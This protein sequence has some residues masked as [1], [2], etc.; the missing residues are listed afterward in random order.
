MLKIIKY[1][2]TAIFVRNNDLTWEW[3]RITA[4][5]DARRATAQWLHRYC[6][7]T[8]VPW[9]KQQQYTIKRRKKNEQNNSNDNINKKKIHINSDMNRRN[10]APVQNKRYNAKDSR[11]FIKFST[12]KM[13]YTCISSDKDTCIHREKERKLAFVQNIFLSSEVAE[14]LCICEKFSCAKW[15]SHKNSNNNIIGI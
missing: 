6:H 2:S 10:E 5:V 13:L 14:I 11:I 7:V 15:T 9:H 3:K 4:E 1:I 8:K 12:C